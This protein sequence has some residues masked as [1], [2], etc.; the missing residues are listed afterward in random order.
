MLCAQAWMTSVTMTSKP[1]SVKQLDANKHSLKKE[2]QW[3]Y[4][5]GKEARSWGHHLPCPFAS[6]VNLKDQSFPKLHQETD[7]PT[8]RHVLPITLV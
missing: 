4:K 3:S 8:C 7:G 1:S 2:L 5:K 6:Q